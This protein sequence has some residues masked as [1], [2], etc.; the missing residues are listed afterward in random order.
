MARL[1]RGEYI[2]PDEIQTIHAVSRI[3]R[4]S[5]LCGFDPYTGKSYEYRR[6]WIRKRIEFLASV[7]GID[8]LTY[9][10]MSNHLHIILRS[11]PDVVKT[12]SDEE[13]AVR[14]LR[15]FPKSRK[16]KDSDEIPEP[17]EPQINEIINNP[18]R[19]AEIRRRLSDVS[20][21]MRCTAEDIARRANKE[22][23]CTGR[24]WEGRFKAQLLLDEASLLACAA[25]VDLNPVRAAMAK[26]LD[27]STFTGICDRVDD[28]KE[29]ITNGSAS[30]SLK[31]DRSSGQ[32]KG[33]QNW[34]KSRP[35]ST[36]RWERSR[37]RRKSGWLSPIEIREKS[38]PTGPDVDKS[39]R[40][41]SK[42]GF[43]PISL[44][45]Y[46]ELLEWTG[47][48]I[49]SGKKGTIP[50]DSKPILDQLGLASS[51]WCELVKSFGRLF[52]RA[53]GKS[54][55]LQEEAERRGQKRLRAPGLGIMFGRKAEPSDPANT[56]PP[57]TVG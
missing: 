27:K 52:H 14:W 42:K 26:S 53:V 25:Y 34:K 24:F 45:R 20:W 50:A 15:L 5:L 12:W 36:H 3:V 44:V 49:A 18:D 41:A 31:S 10:V 11:R 56:G 9:A 47:R 7:F 40:R 29:T 54:E 37:K 51:T 57:S 30:S 21:W 16:K 6:D 8:C 55:H 46:L 4:R 33:R 1:A 17:T 48:Q 38:D 28:L 23:E 32:K 35:K 22:D 13:V 2:H 39:G 19:L 43:L